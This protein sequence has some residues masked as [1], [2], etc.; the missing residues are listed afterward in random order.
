MTGTNPL[1]PEDAKK[2]TATNGVGF[3]YYDR[4]FARYELELEMTLVKG[5]GLFVVAL[6]GLE[7]EPPAIPFRGAA[8]GTEA[9]VVVP[10][11]QSVKVLVRVQADSVEILVNGAGRKW[12]FKGYEDG[13]DRGA[14]VFGLALSPQSELQVKSARIRR[15]P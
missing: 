15:I 1:T 4:A 14:G 10:P 13:K 6:G 12:Q 8:Q 11:G 5:S 9:Q 7:K 3:W 2:D